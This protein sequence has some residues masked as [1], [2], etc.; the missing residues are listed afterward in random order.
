[1]IRVLLLVIVLLAAGCRSSQE[2]RLEEVPEFARV[3]DAAGVHGAF[4]LYDQANDRYLVH[5]GARA[6][7]GFIPASTFKIFNSLVALE[8]GAVASEE[9]VLEWAGVERGWDAWDQDHSMRSAIRVSAVWFYQELARRIGET[10]MQQ[11]LREVRYGNQT[12]D[13]AIDDFW[14]SGGLRITPLEQVDF[15]VRLARNDLPFS[16]RTMAIVRDMLILEER[17]GW[18]LRGKTGWANAF[19]PQVGWFVGYVEREE[20]TYFFAC[21]VDIVHPGDEDARQAVARRII[22][23][24]GLIEPQE[25]R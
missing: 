7:S 12:M 22:E 2:S 17:D 19:T 25:N 13:G 9:E 5:N 11:Y 24:Q 1:M 18:V 8:A 23:Q 3:F 20:G 21:N 16:D 15:L 10:R 6:D 4:V 14:L